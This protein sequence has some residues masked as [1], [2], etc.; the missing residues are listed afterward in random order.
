MPQTTKE[1]VAQKIANY[2]H[3]D[4]ADIV[5]KACLEAL[6]STYDTAYEKGKVDGH[7]K[8]VMDAMEKV[9]KEID[10]ITN[11]ISKTIKDSNLIKPHSIDIII[12]T[13]ERLRLALSGLLK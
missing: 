1:Q 3:P 11:G 13:K 6:S 12:A 7:E 4:T 10:S 5:Y 9:D 8:G 2:A